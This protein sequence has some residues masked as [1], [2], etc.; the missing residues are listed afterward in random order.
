MSLREHI[1]NNFGLKILSL[2][3][4]TLI[5]FAI[6]SNLQVESRFPQN[7]FHLVQARE[8]RVPIALL[9]RAGDPR[10]FRIA[11]QVATIKVRGDE[12]ALKALTVSDLQPFVK[13]T[14]VP[15][16]KGSFLIEVN[17]PRTVRLQEV[18]P[19]HVY[20]EAASPPKE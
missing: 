5:W 17:V 20:V 4:A 8:F 1:L 2:L 18:L 7:L 9:T 11:P 12:A 14:D 13:L 10:V 15:I 3:L 16:P 19:S 6:H